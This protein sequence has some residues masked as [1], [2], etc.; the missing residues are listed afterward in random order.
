MMR[1]SDPVELLD[2]AL[3]A[4]VPRVEGG[5]RL[6]QQYVGLFGRHG[7]VFDA[8]RDDDELALAHRYVAV[9]ELEQQAAFHDEDHLVLQAV[10]MPPE[11]AFDFDTLAL[12][13]G[14]S[15]HDL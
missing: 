3:I 4:D 12:E 1:R 2:R 10:M 11:R 8:A 14:N 5:L 13:T 7:H 15:A 6:E 9:P